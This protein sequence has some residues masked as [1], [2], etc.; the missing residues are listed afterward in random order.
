LRPEIETL[1]LPLDL[2]NHHVEVH[3]TEAERVAKLFCQIGT[4]AAVP[5]TSSVE[6]NGGF[7]R[8]FAWREPFVPLCREAPDLFK[9]QDR[10]FAV[11]DDR[12][13]FALLRQQH[14]RSRYRRVQFHRAVICQGDE[15]FRVQGHRGMPLLK[16]GPQAS[17]R[18]PLP[19]SR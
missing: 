1:I 2:L 10:W 12:R 7:R 18:T 13:K 5:R 3:E 15:L 14:H 4:P 17:T 8:L 9:I 19:I 11:S 6:R 16:A